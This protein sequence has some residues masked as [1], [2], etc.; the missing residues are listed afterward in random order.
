MK[1][2]LPVF[3]ALLTLGACAAP[4]PPPPH[5]PA[6]APK[7]VLVAPPVE[8]QRPAGEW[9]DW[10][11]ASGD[12]V[13]RRDDRG[14]IALFGPSG[15]NAVVTLRC[16][17]QRQRIYLAREGSGQGGRM[18][19]RT[20]SAVKEFVASPAGGTVPYLATEIMPTDPILDAAALS[21]GRIAIETDGQQPLA[22]P[23]WAEIT[24]ITEDC[25][26]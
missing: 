19:V 16:D 14:S 7:P 20:S 13:Y 10:P 5:R 9:V 2:P 1:F 15:Q 22:I 18:V 4:P 26:D 8:Q 12:W 21:R 17:M 6:P 23:S 11:I 3:A 25:R 24:R